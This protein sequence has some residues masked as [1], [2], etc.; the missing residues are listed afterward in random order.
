MYSNESEAKIVLKL[1]QE[2]DPKDRE[3]CVVI[4]PFISQSS[5]IRSLLY[6]NNLSEVPVFLPYQAG[7]TSYDIA[8]VSFV[9]AGDERILRYPLTR[10]EVL[11]TILTSAS[12]QL[13]LVGC[14]DTLRQ[15]RI[16]GEI[17]DATETK[18]CDE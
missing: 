14:R 16:L 10:P 3:R 11:Y 6:E 18:R 9:C 5:L 8:I 1:L 4:T 15:S 17:I 7:R 13:I 2:M 12:K